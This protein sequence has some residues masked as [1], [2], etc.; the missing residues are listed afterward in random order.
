[1]LD[2]HTTDGFT[3]ITA[4][5]IVNENTMFGTGQLPKM[6]EDMYK[7]EEDNMYL[8]P[9]AEVSITNIYKQEIGTGLCFIDNNH[10]NRRLWY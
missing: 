1:M 3:E 4:P 7:T 9:T 10:V 5:Y 2:L 6:A 8:I